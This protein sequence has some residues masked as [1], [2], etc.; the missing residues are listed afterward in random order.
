MKQIVS[1]WLL[2][3]VILPGMALAGRSPLVK[4]GDRVAIFGDSISTGQG[5]GY[6]AVQ[7]M[8]QEQPN[9]K[10]T[11][12]E[13]GHPGWRADHA[14]GAVDQVLAGKPTLVTIM[15]GTNDM[16]QLGARGIADL[17][18]NLKVLTDRF[19]QT[20]VRIVLL[21]PPYTSDT[22]PWGASLDA[23]GL[24]QMAE[25]VFALGKAEHLPVFDMFTVTR[26]A[27]RDGR[28]S[29]PAFQMY[30]APGDVHPNR[31]GHE[32]MARALADY[33]LGKSVPP[34]TR[35]V[36]RHP[37]LP[38]AVA[39]ATTGTVDLLS[40]SPLFPAA[41]P[42]QLR[43]RAQ[44]LY[45]ARWT[46]PQD[47]SAIGTAGWDIDNLY[48][49][50]RVTDNVVIPGDQQPAWG[51]D[52][53]EFFFDTRPTKARNVAWAPGYYQLFVPAMPTNGPVPVFCG[54]MDK[55]DPTTVRAT[56]RRTVDGYL[57][58]LA[59]PWT[60]LR[61]TPKAK[62]NIGFDF[63]INDRDDAKIDRYKALWRGAG[64]DYTNAGALGTLLLAAPATH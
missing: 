62:R 7:L 4:P 38:T 44:I 19:K 41:A 51:Y 64:D 54:N 47:L 27:N 10:L 15:F 37:S 6:L 11:W 53:I 43:D 22:D 28:K 12:L 21:T 18:A 56:Y 5:Y 57:L 39:V 20:G 59:I 48:V 26:Q 30:N 60:T 24:P 17:K 45:P 49:E 33:L 13:N 8:N 36:W 3:C 63:A 46:G 1:F 25:E 42:M 16:G 50:I 31:L 14:A 40:D 55:F 52:G 35:F 34:R 61:F 32:I 2:L 29:Y 58:H 23:V 9:L